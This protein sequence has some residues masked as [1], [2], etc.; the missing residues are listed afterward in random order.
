MVGVDSSWVL[1][2]PRSF[3]FQNRICCQPWFLRWFPEE[4]DP[5]KEWKA[6]RTDLAKNWPT[7]PEK[8]ARLAKRELFFLKI[9]GGTAATKFPV[10]GGDPGGAL[11][12]AQRGRLRVG[13]AGCSGARGGK[14]ARG[15][16]GGKEAARKNQTGRCCF[17]LEYPVVWGI[18]FFEMVSTF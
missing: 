16:G 9:V 17:C 11:L 14:V 8:L 3:F 1:F 18:L 12:A 15:V 2:K 4:K 13:A 5:W 10:D 6:T 7:Q